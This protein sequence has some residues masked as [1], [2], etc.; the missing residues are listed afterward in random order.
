MVIKAA[1][2]SYNKGTYNPLRPLLCIG[3]KSLTSHN[4]FATL[5]SF[6]DDNRVVV[7]LPGG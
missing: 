1:Q 4:L 6:F 3:G 5:N 7:S 2:K